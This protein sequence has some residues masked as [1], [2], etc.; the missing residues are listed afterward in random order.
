MENQNSGTSMSTERNYNLDPKADIKTLKQY[1]NLSIKLIPA[2]DN[3]AFV[4]DRKSGKPL[5]DWGT[6]NKMEYKT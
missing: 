4:K 2:Y 1:L 6:D 3:K 5:R